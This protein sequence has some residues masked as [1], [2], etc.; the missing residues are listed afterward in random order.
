MPDETERLAA[1]RFD[2]EGK[3]IYVYADELAA[4]RRDLGEG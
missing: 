1:L 4:L 2:H 3:T